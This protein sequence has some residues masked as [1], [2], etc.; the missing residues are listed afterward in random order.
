[1][2]NHVVAIVQARMASTR[3][4]SKVLM[5]MI[6]K[7][8]LEQ[9]I[10]RICQVDKINEIVVATTENKL[11]DLIEGF[12]R[13]KGI[14]CFRGS[15]ENV[16]ERFYLCAKQYGAQVIVR[17]TADDPLKDPGVIT[18]AIELYQGGDYDYVSNT[19][20]PT[21]PE[22]IDVEV[23]SFSALEKSYH[24][25]SVPSEIEHVTPYIYKHPSQFKLY[26]F[27]NKVNLSAMC[28]T[29]D[30]PEDYFFVKKIYERLYRKPNEI[31]SMEEVCE[32]LQREPDILDLNRGHVRNEGYQKS[33][34]MDNNKEVHKRIYGNELNY[35]KEVLDS[36]FRSSKG[37]HMMQK[38]EK[39]FA[40]KIG[41]RYA[42]A[43]VNGTCTLHAIL[44]GAG[45]GIGDEVIVPPLTMSST[46]F[47]VLQANATPV[48][49]DVDPDTFLI[50]PTSILANITP[51][52]KAII[53]VALYGLSPDMDAIMEI[54][55]AHNILVIEDNAECMLGSYKGRMVGTLGHAASYSFQ[56][57]KHITSGEGGIVVTDSLEL[58][59][60]VRR[61]SSLGYAGVGASKAKITKQT[62][63][64]P[65]YSRHLSMG[66]N[67]RM[68]ELCA[69][70]ALGQLENVEALVN[71][72]IEVAKLYSEAVAN[73]SWL[74]PQYIGQEYKCT[75]WTYVV[76]LEHPRVTWKEFR[77]QFL[78]FGGDGIYAAW[79]L[80]Y[81]EPMMLELNLLKRDQFIKEEIKQ[82]YR[83]GL[84]PIAEEI[85]GRLLQFKTN[86]WNLED[87]VK[88]VEVLKKTIKYFEE[89]SAKA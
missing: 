77:D 78:D 64:D 24:E 81:L 29:V 66:W 28:W 37:A 8:I 59:E 73:V 32:L 54:A 1:M 5:P 70:V 68:P 48:F 38:L 58:A 87:A 89:W 4:P 51:N 67:Y 21:Y 35:I 71:R 43:L 72:R 45:V 33:L 44:E 7:P 57:S 23:F 26:N 12:C 16:L 85:Q 40:E 69:A 60:G 19:I 6:D 46:T 20:E 2:T 22:G 9:I 88:Q 63:Q 53:T 84:C 55:N 76:K 39:T 25:A 15:E 75:F 13:D 47:A 17:I 83:E 65:N 79:K 42:I 30:K 50:S 49:A 82:N 10:N 62:I 56:S 3:L 36:E 52:T 34:L 27:K 14:A 18:K 41:R 86:Y 31:F 61:V 80:T 74:K 11:D